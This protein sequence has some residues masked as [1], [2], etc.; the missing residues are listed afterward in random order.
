MTKIKPAEQSEMKVVSACQQILPPHLNLWTRTNPNIWD[1]FF[2]LMPQIQYSLPCSFRFQQFGIG[3]NCVFDGRACWANDN[4]E[5]DYR[6][7]FK[8]LQWVN[9]LGV[10]WAT[11]DVLGTNHSSLFIKA[12]ALKSPRSLVPV[13]ICIYNGWKQHLLSHNL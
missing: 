12:G 5:Q 3:E 9:C 2:F 13:I 4:N 1:G 7:E 8:V 11:V 6:I 10:L